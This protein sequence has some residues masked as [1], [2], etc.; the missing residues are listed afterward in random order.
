MNAGVSALA[1]P[2]AVGIVIFAFYHFTRK[3]K[4]SATIQRIKERLAKVDPSF[5][6]LSIHESD[7]SETEDKKFISLCVRDPDTQAEYRTNTLVY[8]ALHEIA[9]V[10]N[11][12]QFSEHG[13]EWQSIFTNLLDQAE[14][15]DIYDPRVPLEEWYCGIN[16]YGHNSTKHGGVKVHHKHLRPG[17]PKRSRKRLSLNL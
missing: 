2:L 15:A 1:I 16:T 14:K 9:H 3:K 4:P 6:N 12:P 13:P 17:Q 8:V 10:K 11:P 5:R 7:R